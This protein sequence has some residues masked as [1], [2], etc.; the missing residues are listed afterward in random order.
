[1]SIP[2]R[3]NQ[4]DHNP[5]SM[6][7]SSRPYAVQRGGTTPTEVMRPVQTDESPIFV[8]ANVKVAAGFPLRALKRHRKLSIAIPAVILTIVAVV[9]AVSQKH[10]FLETRFFAEKNF[11]M[12]ALSNPRRAVTSESDSPTRL[13]AEAVMRRTNLLEIVRQTQLMS[14]WDKVRSPLG[15]LKDAITMKLSG[16]PKESQRL[17]SM[18]GMLE[19]RMWV[20]T[21]EGTVTIGLDWPDPVVGTRIVQTAQQNFFEQRHASEVSL[22]GESIGIL[23]S[24]VAASQSS[25]QAAVGQINA[26]L[27]RRAAVPQPFV[28]RQVSA[29]PVSPAVLALQSELKATQQSISD[30]SS[31]RA[32]RLSA[33][34]TRL[35][36]LRGMY[37]PAHPDVIQTEENIR[38]LS[39]P[40]PQIATLSEQEKSIRDKLAAQGASDV[41]PTAAAASLEPM[42]A[43]QALEQLTRVAVDSQE[44]PEVT[45][46]RS[47]L[48]IATADYEDLLGRLEGAKIEMETAR[49]AFKYRY[50]VI[51]PAAI[52]DTP[53]SPKIPK[54][55]IGGLII[56]LVIA[57]FTA[58]MLDLSGGK[59]LEPWQVEIM[60]GVPVMAEVR[61]R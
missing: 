58:I 15:K 30:I 12:P 21:N 52:P 32:Q 9:I 34:Q 22:I 19:K 35:T 27:P 55:I 23:E 20:T 5:S 18:I 54:L 49:A 39:E 33:L 61:R 50:S 6:V 11:V 25:I 41:S 8:L 37:G 26:A 2:A 7:P 56:A 40:S 42:L 48:K 51:T 45:F 29:R 38:A 16:P 3:S 44:A 28:Q 14:Q 53:S 46:A 57:V 24:Y 4:P 13:A 60:L 43:R 10:Y 1:M 59:V 17:Q 47:R 31:I 36:E